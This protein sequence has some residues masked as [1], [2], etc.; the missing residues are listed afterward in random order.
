[1]T[2]LAMALE[3]GALHEDPF[4]Q[5]Y[6]AKRMEQMKNEVKKGGRRLVF[7]GARTRHTVGTY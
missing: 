3:G 7:F 2:N 6:R 5:D 4:L 1:M